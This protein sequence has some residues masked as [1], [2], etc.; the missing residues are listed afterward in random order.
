MGKK[1]GFEGNLSVEE[2][3]NIV[4][5]IEE[6]LSEGL[7]ATDKQLRDHAHGRSPYCQVNK[8][9]GLAQTCRTAF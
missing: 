4:K 3:T 8:F 7:F 5:A 6:C 2:C 9:N 1:F